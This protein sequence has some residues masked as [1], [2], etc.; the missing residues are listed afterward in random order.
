MWKPVVNIFALS[1]Q[2]ASA[3][4]V[5][6]AAD[7][8]P[9]SGLSPEVGA[10]GVDREITAIAVTLDF[11]RILT[12]NRSARTIIIGNPGII[13]GTLSDDRTIVLTGKAVGTTNMII[14]GEGGAEIANVAVNVAGNKSQLTTVYQGSEQH[15]FSCAGPC[16]PVGSPDNKK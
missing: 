12:F 8:V 14:L 2:V 3:I 9:R 1:I 13:D 15:V 5:Q 10:T 4:V 11:A 7:E 6:A 16:R